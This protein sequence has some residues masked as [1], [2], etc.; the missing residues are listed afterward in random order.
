MK[1]YYCG[2]DGNFRLKNG[3]WCCKEKHTSCPEVRKKN[4]CSQKK[5]YRFVGP[6]P[7][8]IKVKC[9]FCNKNS[10]IS[11]IKKHERICFNN[12]V[13]KKFCIVCGNQLKQHQLK[14][15]TCSH[16]CSNKFYAGLRNKPENYKNYRT[17]CF[18]NN[19]KKCI[20][21][22]EDKIVAVHHF[23]GNNKNNK[24]ENLIPLCPTHHCYVHSGYY[25]L[26]KCRIEEYVNEQCYIVEH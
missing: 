16:S 1:C 20:V 17:I 19:I 22:G 2:E 26:I 9:S 6:N 4:S 24:K 23:D 21:C 7:S 10:N 8:T 12:P 5:S 13:N 25:E 14:Q 18:H 3:N 11:N 15:T